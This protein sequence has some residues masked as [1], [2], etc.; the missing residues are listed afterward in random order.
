M[1]KCF[2]NFTMKEREKERDWVLLHI[3]QKGFKLGTLEIARAK[4]YGKPY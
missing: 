1:S 4:K 3:E 2:K